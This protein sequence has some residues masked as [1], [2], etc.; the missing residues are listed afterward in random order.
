MA[1]LCCGR[2]LLVS[3]VA[4]AVAG[5][6][7]VGVVAA[8][9][10]VLAVR[11]C[12]YGLCWWCLCR[13]VVDVVWLGQPQHQPQPI[14]TLNDTSLNGNLFFGISNHINITFFSS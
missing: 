1:F 14:H 6:A 2:V 11:G 10:V 9:C 4:D 3:A 7:V 13:F 12:G 8:V 5:L